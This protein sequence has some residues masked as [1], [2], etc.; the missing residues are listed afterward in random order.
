[1][2]SWG[3]GH[4]TGTWGQSP[5]WICEHTH[6]SV[7][8]NRDSPNHRSEVQ[9]IVSSEDPLSTGEET[10]RPRERR[11]LA[12]IVQRGFVAELGLAW[13]LGCWLLAPSA[14]A[15][16]GVTTLSFGQH[17]RG[18]RESTFEFRIMFLEK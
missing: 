9:S 11:R 7:P 6:G 17:Y 10:V 16:R 2:K 12:E 15:T 1:M 18:V 14:P 13:A 5:A 4:R 3:E 8:C